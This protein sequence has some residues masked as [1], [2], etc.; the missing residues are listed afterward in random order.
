MPSMSLQ[1]R[2]PENPKDFENLMVVLFE[3]IYK[4]TFNKYGRNGQDQYGADILGEINKKNIVLQCKCFDQS[5]TKYKLTK[6]KILDMV[7]LIDENYPNKCDELFIV[8]TLPND[9]HLT[10]FVSQLNTQRESSLTKITLWGWGDI[11]DRINSSPRTQKLL[12]IEKSPESF[13]NKYFIFVMF[14]TLICIGSYYL[15]DIYQS[16]K[17]KQIQRSQITQVYLKAISD[18]VDLLKQAYIGCLE[19]ASDY[20]F[21]NSDQLHK[22]CVEPISKQA[23]N[24]AKLQNKYAASV[25]NQA[26]D[27]IKV[28]IDTLDK[29][30]VDTYTA[31]QMTRYL[32]KDLAQNL[33]MA[34]YNKATGNNNDF[35][36]K[37]IKDAFN[38]QMYAYFKNRDF[39]IP[40][41]NSIRAQIAII[42]RKM[43]SDALPVDLIQTANQL[44]PL[45]S[46]SN[47]YEYRDYPSNIS[48]VKNVTINNAKF[49][50]KFPTSNNEMIAIHQMSLLVGIINNPKIL[51][52]LIQCGY[53]RP[54]AKKHF[55][56]EKN[57]F[58]LPLGNDKI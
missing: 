29:L 42:S 51:D 56:D 37:Q 38:F 8:H 21:L 49:P 30:A 41:T 44:Q 4:A 55:A 13:N 53:M 52:Q 2:A 10:D 43:N 58:V 16:N 35:M 3:D 46:K 18:N 54:E 39:N 24:L 34:C 27:Q 48:Q 32:E 26:Y 17:I 40:I 28:F 15:Y 45:I 20:L 25:D 14:L 5:N 6:T 11:N 50:D 9:T 23:E 1:Y 36:A 7:Q 57:N 33:Q 31:A 22:Q 47:H 19:S 12:Q